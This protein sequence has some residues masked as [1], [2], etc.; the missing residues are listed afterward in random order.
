MKQ[1]AIKIS[2]LIKDSIQYGSEAYRKILQKDDVAGRQF[3]ADI[4]FLPT[5]IEV[6]QFE[7]ILNQTIAATPDM[8]QYL[9]PFKLLSVA[10][11][12][13]KL[14]RMLFRQAQKRFIIHQQEVAQQNQQATI[15]GQIKSAQ[16]AEEEK[17]ATKQMEMEIEE[18]RTKISS[19]SDNQ[20]AVV[21]MVA[22]W[23]KPNSEGVV[24]KIPDEFKPIVDGVFQNILIGAI[25]QTDEQKEAMIAKMQAA[26]QQ[27]Q[28]TQGEE[29]TEGMPD[30]EEQDE[31]EEQPETEEQPD[32]QQQPEMVA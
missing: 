25:A 14:A 10:K 32:S 30:N 27:Q 31:M 19:L 3:T 13:V 28:Q 21:N 18:R 26:Q 20:S 15:E 9:D 29:P 1:T 23:L 17:R 2:C 12:D 5:Q 6:Q 16:V 11:E 7:A 8:L 24:G 22:N 4:R